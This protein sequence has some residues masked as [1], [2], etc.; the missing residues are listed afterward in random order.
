MPVDK[1]H[2]FCREQ[3]P[4]AADCS[5]GVSPFVWHGD[6]PLHEG[7]SQGLVLCGCCTRGK[8]PWGSHWGCR[9][10]VSPCS[11]GGGGC[12]TALLLPAALLSSL[13]SLMQFPFQPGSA[14]GTTSKEDNSR[15]HVPWLVSWLSLRVQPAPS[16]TTSPARFV[17]GLALP[18]AGEGVRDPPCTHVLPSM[19]FHPGQPERGAG[20]GHGCWLRLCG[21]SECLTAICVAS[22][23][24]VCVYIYMYRIYVY[25]VHVPAG[26]MELQQPPL[27]QAVGSSMV[28]FPLYFPRTVPSA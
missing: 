17:Q 18:L 12:G 3:D 6:S 24:P 1:K 16:T 26:G 21:C 28:Y 27:P 22:N 5:E 4:C 2:G 8:W 15:G 14:T 10:G 13:N 19:D 11:A 9:W 7:R 25:S 23:T 20:W